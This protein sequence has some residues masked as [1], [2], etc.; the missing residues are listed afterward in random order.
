MAGDYAMHGK[1]TIVRRRKAVENSPANHRF[2]GIEAG[3]KYKLW[4]WAIFAIQQ[5]PSDKRKESFRVREG[6]IEILG[7]LEGW[8]TGR[9]EC[10]AS[11][12]V[13][14]Q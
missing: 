5:S 11:T 7:E 6:S 14:T 1:G 9:V 2:S 8:D 13:N 3:S 12:G 4:T 10:F